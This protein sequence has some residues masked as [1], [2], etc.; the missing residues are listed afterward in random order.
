[1]KQKHKDE[2]ISLK[3]EITEL[4]SMLGETMEENL[5]LALAI[6]ALEEEVENLKA[7][8]LEQNIPIVTNTFTTVKNETT[9]FIVTALNFLDEKA[10]AV[11]RKMRNY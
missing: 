2:I 4:S 7:Q 11:A 8:L 5:S 1:M 3:A 6:F 9:P 10:Y